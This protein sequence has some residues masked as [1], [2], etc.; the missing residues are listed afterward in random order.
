MALDLL[1]RSLAGSVLTLAA[2]AAAA[3]P[4]A[5][6]EAAAPRGSAVEPPAPPQPWIRRHPPTRHMIELGIAFGPL[7]P[8]DGHG[9]IDDQI[10]AESEGTFFQRYN[11]AISEFE[12]RA[13]YFPLRV[14]GLEVEGGIA[15]TYTRE[16]RERANLYNF[17]GHLIAQFARWSATPYLLAGAGLLGTS[18]ALG[19][20]VDPA[21]HVGVG[22]KFFANDRVVLRMDVRD[23]LA[24]GVQAPL[25]HYLQLTFGLSF[26]VR[27]GARS[28]R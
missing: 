2:P 11:P 12:L 4:R 14:L 5:Q 26:T 21:V 3:G 6:P 15:P 10:N 27:P 8:P 1:I 20:D 13:A 22:A 7:F 16:Y 18:G 28:R 19:S 9:L 23:A 24:R 25:V 17:R